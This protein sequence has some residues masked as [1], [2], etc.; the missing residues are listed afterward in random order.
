MLTLPLTKKV[1]FIQNFID[2]NIF[3]VNNLLGRNGYM[4]FEEFE[5][6]YPGARTNFLM[7]K[8]VIRSVQQYQRKLN[9]DFQEEF[10]S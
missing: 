10:F 2:N 5:R 3:Y 9:L 8:G 7:Y 4:S 6:K 1:V